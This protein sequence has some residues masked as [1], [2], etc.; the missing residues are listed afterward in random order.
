MDSLHS[1]LSER[2]L[3]RETKSA[4]QLRQF[5]HIMSLALSAISLYLLIKRRQAGFI[6]CGLSIVLFVIGECAPQRLARFER[7]WT[8]FGDV[9]GSIVT[10]II[11]LIAYALVMVP[12]GFFLRL[13]GKDLL[14]LTIDKSAESYW[15]RWDASGPGSRPNLPY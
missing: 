4:E 15:Q 9:L 14:Q 8:K 12:I 2:Q 7:I 13:R 5:A 3:E 6:W 10:P 11:L 1:K